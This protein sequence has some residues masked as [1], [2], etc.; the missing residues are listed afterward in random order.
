M[1]VGKLI[2][3][4]LKAGEIDVPHD[5]PIHYLYVIKG[6]NLKLHAHGGAK[7]VEMPSGAAIIIPE[8]PHQVE[9]VGETDVEIIFVEPTGSMGITPAGHLSAHETNPDHY[10][11]L[12]E[13]ETWFIGE[14]TMGPG[15]EDL[16]HSHHDHLLYALGGNEL[17]LWPGKSM[18]GDGKAIPISSGFAAPIGHGFHVLKN[19]GSEAAKIIFFEMKKG[20]P[21]PEPEP[22]PEP[23]VEPG[24]GLTCMETNPDK[25]KVLPVSARAVTTIA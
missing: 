3:M 12:A 22:V 19:T 25:Y 23:A 13:D 10:K 7:E 2:H 24:T 11:V 6:G 18:K 16:P 15:E 4:S 8:G 14:M 20:N 9:N 21:D 1:P 17:T 5:H